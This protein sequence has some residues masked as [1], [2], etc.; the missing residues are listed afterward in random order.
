MSFHFL[1]SQIRF[2]CQ[3]TNT[4]FRWT[5]FLPECT[6]TDTCANSYLGLPAV[7]YVSWCRALAANMRAGATILVVPVRAVQVLGFLGWWAALFWRFRSGE[8]FG[9]YVVISLLQLL[10]NII[11]ASN[12]NNN[13]N[14]DNNNDNNNNNLNDNMMVTVTAAAPMNMNIVLPGVGR[15]IRKVRKRSNKAWQRPWDA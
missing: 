10:I 8:R 14:N 1:L 5:Q 7:L 13:N 9:G 2:K 6:G 11:N 15:K 3:N 4:T 12:S